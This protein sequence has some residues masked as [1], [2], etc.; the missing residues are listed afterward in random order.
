MRNVHVFTRLIKE[1]VPIKVEDYFI[2]DAK[3]ISWPTT[4]DKILLEAVKSN[5]QWLVLV[6]GRQIIG[7][8]SRET[9]SIKIQEVGFN[10]VHLISLESLIKEV[11]FYQVEDLKAIDY[12]DNEVVI[13][14]GKNGEIKG[15]ID[16]VLDEKTKKNVVEDKWLIQE[17]ETVFDSFYQ[18]IFV[19]DGQGK[20]IRV[21]SDDD[22]QHLGKNVYD[23]ER[24]RVFYPSISAKALKSGN[25]ES[26]LQY[27]NT[28]DIFEIESIPVRDENGQVV[29]VVSITKDSPEV[30]QLRKSLDETKSLLADYQAEVARIQQEKYEEK[31]FIYKSKKMEDLYELIKSVAS[32]DASVL[33]LGETGVGKQMVANQIH[34]LSNRSNKP[35]I[36]INCGA[37]PESL[38][39]S[40]L[41]GYEEGAFSGTRKGGKLGLF[42]IA[43]TGTLFLDEVGEMSISLQVKLLRA[44]QEKLILRVGGTKEK[45]IDVRI[46]AAT[47]RDIA[48]M[49]KKG[50]FRED[51]YYR[52]N[53]VPIHIPALRER[54][55][56]IQAFA[57]NFLGK[58]NRKYNKSIELLPTQM[59]QILN[60]H[61]PG[62]VRELE[63]TMERFVVLE[64]PIQFHEEEV[65]HIH[66]HDHRLGISELPP[67][68]QY[69]EEV[70][71][72]L[73][74]EAINR[75][76]TTREMA[77]YL[78]V[79]QS[80]IVRKLQKYG[81]VKK[82]IIKGEQ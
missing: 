22:Q 2:K 54:K 5:F 7:C 49:V 76:S 51:L 81:L 16:W 66:N 47:N 17:M 4:I 25:R 63:N 20:V 61:W 9:L 14:K 78:K 29:R 19:I 23:L 79:N 11:S 46:I 33:I 53:V 70:E 13:V 36:T 71:K 6:N 74:M 34:S 38:L 82:Q 8:I 26:G 40:E 24:E 42:E 37:I 68:T 69:L 77:K 52:I 18:S 62:N 55:E 28:G 3:C 35:F 12:I 10:N 67:L 59:E 75:C 56:D 65:D 39:E 60:Y 45:K 72:K 80:T 43:D 50:T 58:F 48:Q 57:F 41:F 64:Q 30:N 73:L 32:V 44:L 15:V 1:G 31:T 27:T 21:T